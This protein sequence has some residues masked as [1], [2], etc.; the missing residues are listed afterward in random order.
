[1]DRH[2][3]DIDFDTETAIF[4]LRHGETYSNIAGQV[5][6]FSDAALT[7]NGIE[8]AVHAGQA[9][10]DILFV[11]AYAGDLERQR[12]TASLFWAQNTHPVLVLHELYGLREWNFGG[13][14]GRL[15]QEMWEAIFGASDME[16]DG[17]WSQY[18]VLMKRQ[19]SEGVAAAIVANDPTHKA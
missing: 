9:A 19:G 10:K 14:E 7:D 13:F 8:Q 17:A 6:G 1:M 3:F 5:Q 2:L 16:F 11:A 12:H 15:E 18:E 4:F